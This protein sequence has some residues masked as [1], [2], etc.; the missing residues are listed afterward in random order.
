MPSQSKS[1]QRLMGVAYAVKSGD[2]QLS[3]VDA[4]YRDKVKELVDGMSL[5]DLKD[6]A[7]TKHDDVPEE[8]TEGVMKI[9]LRKILTRI[10]GAIGY[11]HDP[12]MREELLSAFEKDLREIMIKH[13]YIVEAEDHEVGM[14]MGQ[15]D[16]IHN[17]ATELEDKIF[18]EGD[19]RNIPAWIQS[20]ITSAYEYL[21][22]A[23]DN[24]H[25]LEESS[26]SAVAPNMLGGM[27]DAVLPNGDATGSG[28]VP[29]G[30]GKAKKKKK[31][32]LLSVQEFI[33]EQEQL[34]AFKPEQGE[35]EALGEGEYEV[36]PAND[37]DLEMEEARKR[38][39]AATNVITFSNF[40]QNR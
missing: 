2:M 38:K 25:E 40:S 31:K 14:A 39:H 21:K 6:F 19:E 7:E 16:A 17:A 33:K 20:H 36:G 4:S 24:F 29:A 9:D 35:G 23:N 32:G 26:L 18:K 8:V 30:S 28:D 12:K 11:K 3:D 10:S 34:K 13:D 37:P 27:G 1:Q 22:Q 5:K 15:L